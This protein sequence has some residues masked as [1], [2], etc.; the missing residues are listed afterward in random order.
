MKNLILIT[1]LTLSN[2]CMAQEENKSPY[3]EIPDYSIS[4]T[5]GAVMARML[6][7][8]G[9]RYY[10]ATEGLR[11]EDLNY[12]PSESGRSCGETINHIL[13]LSNFIL[14]AVST[15]EQKKEHSNLSFDEKRKLTLENLK[16]A[17]EIL[18]VTEDLSQ[19]DTK[20]PFWNIINGP[21]EDA[22][23]HCGQIVL[24]RRASGNPF[25]SKVSLFTGKLK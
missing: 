22:V 16:K 17:S 1:V 24:L 19:F 12:K 8:L 5:A 10:W 13:G 23:W 6:D 3:Q 14:N 15:S 4:Y 11:D 20:F 2:F 21:I 25:T 7:G 18:I 9:F